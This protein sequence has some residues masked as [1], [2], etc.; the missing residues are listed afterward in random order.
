VSDNLKCHAQ[1]SFHSDAI[2]VWLFMDRMG[3][4]R[5]VCKPL[6]LVERNQ[7][8]VCDPTM[9]LSYDDAK[10]ILDALLAAGVKPSAEGSAGEVSAIKLHLADMRR[11]VFEAKP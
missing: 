8:E 1:Y 2:D 7:G 9:H 6:L 3:G 10:G 4:G 11:L 5:A